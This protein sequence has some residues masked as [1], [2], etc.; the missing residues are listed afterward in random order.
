MTRC[1]SCGYEEARTP[2]FLARVLS[3]FAGA[4]LRGASGRQAGADTASA[5][6]LLS[7]LRAGESAVVEKFLKVADVRKFLSL[8]VLPGTH[9]TVV[10][11]S[12]VVVLRV[13]YSEFAFD[14][15]LA[16]TVQVHRYRAS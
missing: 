8:G 12:P 4:R 7:E 16:S 2:R 14:R 11:H 5:Q 3:F 1:P 9:V 10:R 13:G 6:A 15:A